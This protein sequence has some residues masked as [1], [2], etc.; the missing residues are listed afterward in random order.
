[1]HQSVMFA[2]IGKVALADLICSQAP[3][4]FCQKFHGRGRDLCGL[5]TVVIAQ[6]GLSQG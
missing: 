6:E 1:M 4:E 3:Q 5:P 2:K